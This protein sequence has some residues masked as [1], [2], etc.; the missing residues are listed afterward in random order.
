[1]AAVNA[2]E[3]ADGSI[4]DDEL[5]RIGMLFQPSLDVEELLAATIILQV[6]FEQREARAHC[7]AIAA[8]V[9]PIS[10]YLLRQCKANATVNATVR[11]QSGISSM[12]FPNAPL[13]SNYRICRQ[14]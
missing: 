5:R 11:N 10:T 4:F 7:P 6:L 14:T 2:G 1:M 3:I 13:R 12:K 9:V 8:P